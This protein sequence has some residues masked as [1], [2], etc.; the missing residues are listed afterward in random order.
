M[1]DFLPAT[2]LPLAGRLGL[3]L[4]PGKKA[5]SEFGP[6]WDRDLAADLQRLRGLYGTQTL[7]CLLEDQEMAEL[8]IPNLVPQAEALGMRVLRHPVRDGWVPSSRDLPL[9]R[10]VVGEALSAVGMGETVV[11]HCRGGLGR[12]GTFAACCILEATG[13]T[14]EEAIRVVREARDG[15]IEN[16]DQER[17][18]ARCALGAPESVN[19]RA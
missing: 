11:V 18:V 19:G 15:A 10:E 14:P 8:Q 17:F 3:T 13:T 9:Y 4:A 12:A 5:F 2:D 1:V 16:A 6:P 7:V